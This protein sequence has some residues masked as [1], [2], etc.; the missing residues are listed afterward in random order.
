MTGVPADRHLTQSKVV[1]TAG[2]HEARE[3]LAHSRPDIL[4]DGLSLFNPEL[5][6]DNYDEL[7]PWLSGYREIARTHGTIIYAPSIYAPR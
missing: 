4:I 2:T 5:S 1:L 7:R 3:E 6:L